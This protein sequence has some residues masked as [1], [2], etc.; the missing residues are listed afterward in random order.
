MAAKKAK[1]AKA[2]PKDKS[3]KAEVR[4]GL[5]NMGPVKFMAK[6]PATNS[7]KSA[8]DAVKA[9]AKLANVEI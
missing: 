8:L 9:R 3:T 6:R 7:A 5:K 4:P 2:Y 1:S